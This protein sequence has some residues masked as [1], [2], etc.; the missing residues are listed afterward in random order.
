MKGSRTSLKVASPYRDL[1]FPSV[2]TVVVMANT[3]W[4]ACP[5]HVTQK[6][7]IRDVGVYQLEV[8][9]MGGSD[10]SSPSTGYLGG[11]G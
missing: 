5:T 2:F 8:Q 6:E 7:V 9:R 1:A 4:R 10:G 3:R 11:S